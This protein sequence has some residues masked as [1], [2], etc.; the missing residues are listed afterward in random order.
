LN[1]NLK[2]MVN[3]T[4]YWFDNKLGT[5]FSFN[6]ATKTLTKRDET[7]WELA[8]SFRVWW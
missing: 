4:N 5:P 8:T 6:P 2:V 7:F 1:P 3:F